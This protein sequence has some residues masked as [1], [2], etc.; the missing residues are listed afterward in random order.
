[1]EGPRH[2][3][4]PLFCLHL[5]GGGERRIPC[6]RD[7]CVHEAEFV[8]FDSFQTCLREVTGDAALLRSSSGAFL[9][10]EAVRS[11]DSPKAGLKAPRRGCN[12]GNEQFSA[13][14]QTCLVLFSPQRI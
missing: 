7:E 11:C 5:A 12:S 14:R 2:L 1:M 13:Q 4:S 6:N 9:S 8:F 10:V 3:P